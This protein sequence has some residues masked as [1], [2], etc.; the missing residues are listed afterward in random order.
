MSVK[1]A[2]RKGGLSK[3]PKKA[4]AVRENGKKVWSQAVLDTNEQVNAINGHLKECA[5]ACSKIGHPLRSISFRVLDNGVAN[6]R[7]TYRSKK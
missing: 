7:I 6:M 5:I 1:E 4:A 3:T 2:G